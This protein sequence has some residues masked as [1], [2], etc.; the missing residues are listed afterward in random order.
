MKNFLHC[1]YHCLAARGLPDP[2]V[3]CVDKGKIAGKTQI[4]GLTRWLGCI[5]KD[6]YTKLPKFFFSAWW[7]FIVLRLWSWCN[8]Y[9]VQLCGFYY[10][11]F[12]VGSC[13]A[14]H[15]H[16]FF[17]I[18]IAI[19][20]CNSDDKVHRRKEQKQAGAHL[21]SQRNNAFSIINSFIAV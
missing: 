4:F 9:F 8:S 10:K 14:P 16:F 12:H 11:A 21:V 17:S 13:L 18:L 7:D 5:L 15:C 1:P 3:N 6:L 2:C 20:S 19:W